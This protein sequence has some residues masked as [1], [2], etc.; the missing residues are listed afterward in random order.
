MKGNP[1]EENIPNTFAPNCINKKFSAASLAFGLRRGFVDRKKIPPDIAKL[2]WAE[3]HRQTERDQK[4]R[5]KQEKDLETYKQKTKLDSDIRYLADQ[6]LTS[7]FGG[8]RFQGTSYWMIERVCNLNT[9]QL[10]IFLEELAKLINDEL[11]DR[12]TE[13]IKQLHQQWKKP[14]YI[15]IDEFLDSIQ[16]GSQAKV[17]DKICKL[18]DSKN[19]LLSFLSSIIGCINGYYKDKKVLKD[20]SS[21]QRHII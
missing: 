4:I 9:H 7:R 17:I 15:L 19:E 21:N 10:K 6:Y 12:R 13:E 20:L 8:P 1:Y 5:K 16:L 18:D 3:L 11:I 2:A 14:K